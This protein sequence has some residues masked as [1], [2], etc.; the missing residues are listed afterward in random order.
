MKTILLVL[1]TIISL[2]IIIISSLSNKKYKDNCENDDQIVNYN[3]SILFGALLIII[4]VGILFFTNRRIVSKF[5][6]G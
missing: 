1:I 5:S 2:G 3:Y 4:L 6:F